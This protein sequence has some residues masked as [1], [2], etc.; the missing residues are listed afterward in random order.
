MGRVAG[1]ERTPLARPCRRT[2]KIQLTPDSLQVFLAYWSPD[3]RQLAMM[4]REPGKAWQIYRVSADGGSPERLLHEDRNAGDPSWSA[5]GQSLVFGR[6]TDLMGK[7]NGPRNLQ[8][9]NLATHQIT[10]VPGSDEL[11]SPRWSPDGRY[12]AALSLDQRKLM[13]YEVATQTWST[14]AT[15]SV[16]DPVWS[17]D[18]KSIYIHAFMADAQPIYRVSVPDGHLKEVANLSAFRAG[19][20]ADYFFV[21]I[22]P[23]NLP[24][25]RARTSTG[26]L[27]SLNLDDR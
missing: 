25:V 20:T 14:L 24:L 8:I 27:Y 19:D 13:L 15:T 7:E 3:G 10:S 11:F 23:D 16:A 12:I 9:L 18:G 2:E 1:S 21:G 6:V 17:S 5:D 4:A 26:N 22:T